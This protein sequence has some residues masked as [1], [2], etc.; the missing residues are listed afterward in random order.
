MDRRRGAAGLAPLLL[1]VA[2]AQERPG[3]PPEHVLLVTLADTRADRTSAWLHRLPTTRIRREDGGTALDLDTIADQGVRFADAYSPSPRTEDSLVSLMTGCSMR[4]WDPGEPPD[5]EGRTTLAEAFAA[6]G[7]ETVAFVS[8]PASLAPLGLARGFAEYVEERDAAALL[9]RAV[10]W[11]R[12][13]FDPDK[14]TL[15]WLHLG[16][17]AEP[18]DPEPLPGEE[19]DSRHRFLPRDAEVAALESGFLEAARTGSV[20]V[21][22]AAARTLRGAYDAD[23]ARTSRALRLFF[24]FFAHTHEG[25]RTLDRTLVV[26]AGTDGV[27]LGE[28]GWRRP[29]ALFGGTLHVPLVFRHPPSLTGRRILSE[30]VELADVAPT[31]CEWMG[32]E[33]PSASD[34]R[35]LLPLVDSYVQREFPS[36]PA[37]ARDRHGARSLRDERWRLVLPGEGAGRAPELYDHRVD[38]LERHDVSGRHPGLVREWCQRHLGGS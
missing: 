25:S 22:E 8:S 33:T 4:T 29:D 9:E 24:E 28:R 16:D 35:T 36:R 15:V 5:L 34:G 20:E 19:R 3:V 27:E 32:V 30:V 18:W 10:R 13:G 38:P 6:R 23:L 26:I 7:F 17:T 1:A 21:T 14:P 31:I 12:T 11:I 2:C 37:F